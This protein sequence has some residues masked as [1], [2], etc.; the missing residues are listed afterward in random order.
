MIKEMD[1]FILL[2]KQVHEILEVLN[3]IESIISNEAQ[4]LSL[5]DESGMDMIEEMSLVKKRLTDEV[6]SLEKEFEKRYFEIKPFLHDPDNSELVRS[7]Q[8]YIKEVLDLK[9]MI[10]MQEQS[11]MSLIQ[12]R[13]KNRL[14]QMEIPKSRSKIIDSYKQ[15]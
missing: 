10:I 7:L 5:D 9:N 3:Q 14:G 12:R 8:G 6:E 2:D 15:H 13:L 1:K 11:N 4:I